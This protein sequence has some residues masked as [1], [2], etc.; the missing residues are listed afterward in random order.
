MA[1]DTNH[2]F[3]QL[4][5]HVIY[6]KMFR[7][8]LFA[9]FTVIITI[10]CDKEDDLI[11]PTGQIN[12][13][14]IVISDT[15]VFNMNNFIISWNQIFHGKD[16]FFYNYSHKIDKAGFVSESQQNY[17]LTGDFMQR[18]RFITHTYNDSNV[19]VSSLR[20]SVIDNSYMNDQTTYKYEYDD[21]GFIISLYTYSEGELQNISHYEYDDE[22]KIKFMWKDDSGDEEDNLYYGFEAKK[23][24]YNI[25]GGI[26]K[27]L[28]GTQ[29]LDGTFREEYTAEYVYNEG[30]VVEVVEEDSKG[31]YEYDSIGR[32]ITEKVEPQDYEEYVSYTYD[33]DSIG[34]HEVY[35]ENDFI[36]STEW[37]RKD[38]TYA[39]NLRYSF[40]ENWNLSY[41]IKSCYEDWFMDYKSEYYEGSSID[42]A[43]LIGY[44]LTD[45]WQEYDNRLKA[46][47]SVYSAAGQ[48]LYYVT[49]SVD[50]DESWFIPDGT[51][52][53]EEDVPYWVLKITGI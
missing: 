29:K 8:I 52:V 34:I 42:E 31:I 25:L 22:H 9:L 1:S 6:Y 43:V 4:F 35:Y 13:E 10:S 49:Y 41:Y 12:N 15:S 26:S 30:L 45:G 18:L 33:G 47:Q 24:E 20:A 14:T 21:E 36:S 40:D 28:F 50:E 32:I 53:N 44:A 7:K 27:I 48:K 37:I 39:E 19:I 46:Q 2:F 5:Y 17:A 51:Q 38:L 23:Y 16:W 3:G 11:S